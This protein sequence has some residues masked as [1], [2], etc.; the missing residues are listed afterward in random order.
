M[1]LGSHLIKEKL[2]LSDAET[3]EMIRENP[4]LQFFIGMEGFGSKVPFDASMM[5]WFRKR[6]TPE[7][8]SEVKEYVI[9]GERE[10]KDDGGNNDG[11]GDI[12]VGASE[13]QNEEKPNKGTM[14]IDATCAPVEFGPKEAISMVDG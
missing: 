4:Y 2:R 6:M 11:G 12:T 3:V 1:A 13:T 5:T 10:K 14:I 9:K 8:I 7:I